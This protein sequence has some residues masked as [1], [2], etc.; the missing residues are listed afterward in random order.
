MSDDNTQDTQESKSDKPERNV[1]LYNPLELFAYVLVGVTTVA[2]SIASISHDFF[3]SISGRGV[4]KQLWE[5]RDI[6]TQNLYRNSRSTKELVEG[7]GKKS[8]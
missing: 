1:K 7:K 5:Q 2:S 8:D 3:K 6:D 4:F